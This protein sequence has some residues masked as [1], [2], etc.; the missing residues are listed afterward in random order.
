MHC[1]C[2]VRSPA[3]YAPVEAW[4]SVA[5]E[6]TSELKEDESAADSAMLIRRFMVL[7]WEELVSTAAGLPRHMFTRKKPGCVGQS[8]S[9]SE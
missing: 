5:D 1:E 4:A 8:V 6:R 9:Q 7:R 3:S 2:K